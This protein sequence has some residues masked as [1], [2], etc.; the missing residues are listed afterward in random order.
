MKKYL[1]D[2]HVHTM[3]SSVCGKISASEI[4]SMYKEAGYDGIVITDHYYDG[5]FDSLAG[6]EWHEKITRY[7]AGYNDA[8]VEGEKIGLKVLHGIEFRTKF[9]PNDFL[10]YGFDKDFLVRHEMLYLKNIAELKKLA[11][12]NGALVYQAHPFRPGMSP[13]SPS[14]LDGVEVM[15]GNPRQNSQNDLAEIFARNNNLRMISSSD[16][17][18]PEDIGNGGIYLPEIPQDIHDFVRI[19]KNLGE[20]DMKNLKNLYPLS[21][22]Q[23]S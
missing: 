5:F 6:I 19:I 1:F 7:L 17:H 15:N 10:V 2:P 22:L 16:A 12:E 14:V 20:K 13:E 21:Q 3:E 23:K 11:S 18:Q 8:L 4:C 9:S